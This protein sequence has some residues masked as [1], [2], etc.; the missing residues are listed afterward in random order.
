MYPVNL[1][2]KNRSEEITK[3]QLYSIC[4]MNTFPQD[5]PHKTY[6]VNLLKKNRSEEITKQQLYSI[7]FMNTFP[8]DFPHKT[9]L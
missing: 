7:C 3:Q 2:K 6:P 8:Q 5:F 9:Y 4:F 1:L